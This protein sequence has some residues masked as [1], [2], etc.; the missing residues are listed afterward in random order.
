MTNVLL[1]LSPCSRKHLVALLY[2]RGLQRGREHQLILQ[3]LALLKKETGVADGDRSHVLFGDM[4]VAT[5]TD[6]LSS[7]PSSCLSLLRDS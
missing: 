7:L 5:N 3:R 6:C 1:F 4:Q 2:F